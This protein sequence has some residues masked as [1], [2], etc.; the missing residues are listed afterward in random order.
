VARRAACTNNI[1]QITLALLSS[2]ETSKKFPRGAYTNASKKSANAEDGLG[3]ATRILP[4][5]EEQGVYDQIVH[6]GLPG[7]DGDPWK[8]SDPTQ[9]GGIFKAAYSAGKIP[10]PGGDAA[11][12]VFR[13]PSADL[14]LVVPDNGYFGASG[15]SLTT[16]YG[17]AHYKGSRG[18]CDRGMF[19]RTAEGLRTATCANVDL[20]GDGVLDTVNKEPYTRIRIQDVIDG[21]SKT[22]AIGEAAYFASG[23]GENTGDFPIWFGTAWEDGSTLFKTEDL[24]NCNIGGAR[25]FPLSSFESAQLPGGSSSDDC[26]FSWH[27]GGAN[28]GFVDGSVHFLTENLELR[29]FALLGDRMD[30]EVIGDLK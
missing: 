11:I 25:A 29:L 9:M 12:A 1:K 5:I 7:F 28:F 21:T 20:D 18:Y 2:H 4:Y 15:V 16:G 6:N 14:P 30:G 19:W 17:G 27:R 8:E 10:L 26:A 24:I 13:C 23:N 3:W 22:I